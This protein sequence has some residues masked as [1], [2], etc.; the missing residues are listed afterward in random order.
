M[1]LREE[2]WLDW[3]KACAERAQKE[4]FF[5]LGYPALTG[6]ANFCRAYGAEGHR[7]F[8]RRGGLRS[9]VTGEIGAKNSQKYPLLFVRPMVSWGIEMAAPGCGTRW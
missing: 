8:E 9:P 3:T 6:W 5:I 4:G 1:G 7:G 2:A